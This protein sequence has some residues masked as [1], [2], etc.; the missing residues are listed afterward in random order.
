MHGKN[1]AHL[2]NGSSYIKSVYMEIMFLIIQ[3]IQFHSFIHDWVA[4]TRQ[5]FSQKKKKEYDINDNN[6]TCKT[7]FNTKIIQ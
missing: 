7:V 3:N 5:Q 1:G 6:V 4:I 2:S